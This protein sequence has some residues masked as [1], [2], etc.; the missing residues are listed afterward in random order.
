MITLCTQILTSALLALPA[1][2]QAPADVVA[3]RAR[4]DPS[5]ES[6]RAGSVVAP[7]ALGDHERTE[8]AAAQQRT[9]TLDALRAGDGPTNDEWTWIAI[10]AAIVLLIILI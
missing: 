9:T 2:S 10:G 7:T 1:Q 4:F 8:L 6:L 5:L 3:L